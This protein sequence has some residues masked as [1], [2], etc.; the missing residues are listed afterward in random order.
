MPPWGGRWW[1]GLLGAAAGS[2]T[3]PASIEGL[4]PG[5]QGA[6]S[7]TSASVPLPSPSPHPGMRF[8]MSSPRPGRDVGE[9]CFYTE[10][11]HCR[12]PLFI[13]YKVLRA[14]P[15]SFNLTIT[16]SRSGL[17]TVLA[18]GRGGRSLRFRSRVRALL[19]PA[20]LW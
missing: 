6:L 20:S 7:L 16:S 9:A 14:P 4:C 12:K 13:A 18:E 1:A 17:A 8:P 19:K 5:R 3:A 11:F 15:P 2:T 10:S